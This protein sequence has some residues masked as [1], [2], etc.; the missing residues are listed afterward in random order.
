[1][2]SESPSSKRDL[3]LSE[4]A[5]RLEWK[6]L[7]AV[8]TGFMTAL[9]LVLGVTV[10]MLQNA[11]QAQLERKQG[12]TEDLRRKLEA[13]EASR[14]ST[15]AEKDRELSRL[16]Q[17]QS[18]DDRKAQFLLLCMT[19]YSAVERHKETVKQQTEKLL[20]TMYAEMYKKG[21]HSLEKDGYFI[22]KNTA[23]LP[24]EGFIKFGNDPS[25]YPI[26]MGVKEALLH[27]LK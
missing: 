24:A 11:H 14:A 22:R 4:V 20:G 12:E 3:T 17:N 15:V 27:A 13:A 2:S 8:G 23:V 7:C 6:G 26:P 18:S 5:R 21:N 25:E 1:M 9:G 16:K 19:Y 10:W